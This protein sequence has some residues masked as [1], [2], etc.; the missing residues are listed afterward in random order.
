MT[1]RPLGCL[2]EVAETLALTLIIFLIIQNFVA[3]PF[4]VEQDSMEH[5]LEPNQYVLVDKLTP[6][7]DSYKRGDIVVFHPPDQPE[8]SV[9]YIKRIIGLPGDRLEFKDGAVWVDGQRLDEPYVY[10][11]QPTL[12]GPA[13]SLVVVPPGEYFG[14]GDH[15][16]DSVDSRVFGPIPAGNII[17]RAVLRYW[18]LDALAVLSGPTYA[19][20]PAAPTDPPAGQSS[21]LTIQRSTSRP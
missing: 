15:R 6:H 16:L 3:Q 10:D 1:N 9:P 19:N 4:M 12:A 18:P 21:G 20:V 13:G 14:M 17:G 8:S 11:D 2:L 7:L 5:T